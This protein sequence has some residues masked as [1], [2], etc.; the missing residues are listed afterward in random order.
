MI[1]NDLEEKKN[2]YENKKNIPI[3]EAKENELNYSNDSDIIKEEYNI[4]KN[5][6][7]IDDLIN[8]INS[9]NSNNQDYN[10]II[11]NKNNINNNFKY[12][13]N[14]NEKSEIK[15]HEIEKEIEKTRDLK[16]QMAQ[17][18]NLLDDLLCQDN[19]NKIN[20]QDN[21]LFKVNI[22]QYEYYR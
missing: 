6:D 17:N 18:R 20:I 19:I 9:K 14:G 7:L 5:K 4:C 12:N 21:E 16:I 2:K 8:G 10:N 1:N 22:P 15:E 3:N 11:I 13:I